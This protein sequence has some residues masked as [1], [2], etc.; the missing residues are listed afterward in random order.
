MWWIDWLFE[1]KEK[2]LKGEFLRVI[3]NIWLKENLNSFK[4]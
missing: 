2:I 3:L 4:I 1:F